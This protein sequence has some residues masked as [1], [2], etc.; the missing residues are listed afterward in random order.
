MDFQPFQT[1]CTGESDISLTLLKS[2][3]KVDSDTVQC[4]TLGLMHA[5]CPSEDERYLC[6]GRFDIPESAVDSEFLQDTEALG[7]VCEPD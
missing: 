5:E 6:P 3:A 2:I 7:A 4:L 1:C